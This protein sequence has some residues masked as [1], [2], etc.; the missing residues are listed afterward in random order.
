MTALKKEVDQIRE[1][2]F[3]LDFDYPDNDQIARLARVHRDMTSAERKGWEQKISM[4][5]DVF[6]AVADGDLPIEALPR[7][8]RD[9][10]DELLKQK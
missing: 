3:E 2:D 6:K 10:L 5:E 8:I 1:H 7:E 4:A 9:K